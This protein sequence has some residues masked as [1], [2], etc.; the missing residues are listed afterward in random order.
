MTRQDI[1]DKIAEI[2]PN[3]K[4]TVCCANGAVLKSDNGHIVL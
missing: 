4:V 2:E 3:A 1:F